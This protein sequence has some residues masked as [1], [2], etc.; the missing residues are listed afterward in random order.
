VELLLDMDTD[1]T[2]KETFKETR[3][4]LHYGKIIQAL[5]V[6]TYVKG[7][8]IPTSRVAIT[9]TRSGLL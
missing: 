8:L 5:D 3:F 9:V 4:T 7:L 1:L 2:R 6:Y